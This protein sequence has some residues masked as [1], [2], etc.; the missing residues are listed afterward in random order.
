[1]LF[2]LTVWYPPHKGPDVMKKFVEATKTPLPSF[3]KKW[4]VYTTS[5]GERGVKSY[6]LI[7]T[8]EGNVDEAAI[9]IAKSQVPF[10]E[11]EGYVH[12]IEPLLGVKDS[13][14]VM[15]M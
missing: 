12:K 11:I 6:H 4:Q 10:S 9:Y 3:I 7:A 14:K 2:M 5:D 13:F 1:M 8:E 15:G